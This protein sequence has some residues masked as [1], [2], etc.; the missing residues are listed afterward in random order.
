MFPGASLLAD[1]SEFV[2]LLTVNQPGLNATQHSADLGQEGWRRV[3]LLPPCGKQRNFP[4]RGLCAGTN[5]DLQSLV[6]Y[7]DSTNMVTT[8]SFG[9]QD[10]LLK[11]PLE[12]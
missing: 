8:F 10:V 11:L 6:F 7:I 2:L 3:H 5:V 9:R 1:E 12:S 4:N